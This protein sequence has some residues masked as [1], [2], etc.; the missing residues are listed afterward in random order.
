MILC[1]YSYTIWQLKEC[2]EPAFFF[3]TKFL[4]L[5]PSVGIGGD[6]AYGDH[7]NI[8]EV[9]LVRNSTTNAFQCFKGKVM[10][11]A[12]FCVMKE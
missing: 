8:D 4:H 10:R 2:A 7:K 11:G 1:H 9:V 3:I 5:L 12:G 6:G